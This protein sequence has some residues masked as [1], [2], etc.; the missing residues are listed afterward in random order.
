[1]NLSKIKEDTW[2]F[3]FT[4]WQLVLRL[5]H[6]FHVCLF[7]CVFYFMQT[8]AMWLYFTLLYRTPFFGG[9]NFYVRQQWNMYITRV[10]WNC[11]DQFFGL[12]LFVSIPVH[13]HH[14]LHTMKSIHMHGNNSIVTTCKKYLP[15]TQEVVSAESSLQK[16]FFMFHYMTC[17]ILMLSTWLLVRRKYIFKV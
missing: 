9:F 11:T 15:K 5:L 10:H 2:A 6:V 4:S 12:L 7:V 14:I 3:F 1:M 16:Y 17:V 8:V 13:R